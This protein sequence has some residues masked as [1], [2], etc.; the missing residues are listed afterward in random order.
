MPVDV[1]DLRPRP[2]GFAACPRCPYRSTGTPALCFACVTGPAGDHD[3]V[4]GGARCATCRQPQDATGRCPNTVCRLDDRF[5]TR[6]HTVT[7]RSEEM[8]SAVWSY[9][10]GEDRSWAGVLGR[11][12]VGYLDA[13]REEMA[14]YDLITTGAIYV[15]PRAQRLWDYLTLVVQ[16]A[17]AAGPQ[18]PFAPGLIAK[19][20]PTGRFLGIGP[21]ARR[22]IAEG[23]LRDLLSV[24]DPGRV[25]GRRVLVFDD[26]Y[27]EGYS[28]REMARA[29]LAAGAAQ[30]D[31]LVLARRKGG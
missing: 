28:L 20:G 6:I 19:A 8:W 5:F 30:V 17:Q 25:A 26:V 2:A 7:E 23:E 27:S 12:L 10:Y 4:H 22:E 13:H 15:G 16:A 31:G 24:P 1:Q 9:K 3:G 18:W 14:G 11:L 29:L 21:E